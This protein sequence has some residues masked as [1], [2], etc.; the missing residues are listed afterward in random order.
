MP[1]VAFGIA[2]TVARSKRASAGGCVNFIR[3]QDGNDLILYRRPGYTSVTTVGTNQHR[4]ALNAAGVAYMVVGG[5]FYSMTS[6]YTSTF[7]GSL[8]T[9]SGHVSMSFDGT[10]V[11]IVDGE[12][13]YTYNIE[14]TTFT[15]HADTDI[16][17][18][19]TSIEFSDGFHFI[20]DPV[21]GQIATHEVAYN[22]A[23]NWDAL[24]FAT[25][26]FSPDQ[27]KT[28]IATKATLLLIG[29]TST[30][31]WEYDRNSIALPL[32]PIRAGYMEYGTSAPF[33]AINYDNGVVWMSRDKNGQ[34][35]FVKSSGI[36]V[37]RISDHVVEA[38]WA[39]YDIVDDAFSQV[40]WWEGHP[41]LIVTFPDADKTW[42]YDSSSPEGM[43]WSEWQ[44]G[45][46]TPYLRGRMRFAWSIN[47]GGKTLCGDYE[48]NNVYEISW[49]V[50]TD[51]G[52]QIHWSARSP[53]MKGEDEPWLAHRQLTI[54]LEGGVG[55][56]DSTA[57]GHHPVMWMRYTDDHGE[58]WIEREAR[59]MGRKGDYSKRVFWHQLGASRH[60]IYE[61][62]GTE[63][64]TTVIAGGYL[65]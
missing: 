43:Q 33:T 48:N 40:W 51:N 29:E 16:F 38:E 39:K 52:E 36:G 37:S 12:H 59:E 27:L 41:L 1:K 61:L 60:R 49:D 50:H 53:E 14:T 45:H 58:N 55:L 13:L 5:D 15:R 26:E 20:N 3:E 24:D 23:G 62:Y 63:P 47:L 7:I 4:G 25:A 57:Q 46:D 22:P 31:P 17:D 10:Y 19:P 28:I 44:R 56:T 21:T 11:C 30:E 64:V 42:V 54:Y 34:G 2:P 8:Q 35:V 32:R 65:A 9:V 18:S 6:D